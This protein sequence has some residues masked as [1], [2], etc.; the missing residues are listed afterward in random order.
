MRHAA[1]RD[2]V[3]AASDIVNA[4]RA[5]EDADLKREAAADLQAANLLDAALGEILKFLS[6]RPAGEK[7]A[8]SF[9]DETGRTRR[10]EGALVR[11]APG[12]L[13]LRNEEEA[14]SVETG[15]ILG[16]S[17][18]DLHRARPGAGSE[19][20]RRTA[21]LFCLLDGDAEAARRHVP[22]PGEVLP[23]KYWDLARALAEESR[24]GTE[25]ARR[26]AEARKIFR[27]AVREL[28]LP[29]TT[30][31]G[32]QKIGTLLEDFSGTA[33]VRRN[34]VSLEARKNAG[35]EYYFL[36]SDLAA[37]GTFRLG[38]S[39]KGMEALISGADVEGAAAKENFVEFEFSAFPGLE[40][41]CWALLGGCCR[42][43]FTFYQQATELTMPDPRNPRQKV[44]ADPGGACAPALK[45]S[46]PNL[47]PSHAAHGGKKEPT[48]FEWVPVPL[49]SYAS[50]GPKTVRL[51]AEV[52]GAAVARVLVSSVRKE[53][54]RDAELAELERTRA[55]E[56][57]LGLTVKPP[58]GKILREWWTGLQGGLGGLR[59][60]LRQK[61]SGSD[62][63]SSFAAPRDWADNYGTRIRGYLHPPKK[64][65]YVFWIA[66]DNESELWLSA[67]EDPANK[68]KIA[69][70][71]EWTGPTEW[72]KFKEQKSEPV[73]L[74]PGRRYYVE[75]LHVEGQGGDHVS[76]GWQL[77]DGTKE[78]PIPGER[79]SEFK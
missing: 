44:P 65:K 64:G 9:R 73:E 60:R 53:V 46:I 56:L 21:A 28:A 8:L 78:R 72:E 40:Y 51:L 54:P 30:W 32:A 48:R 3:S 25:A 61:P 5:L 1:A 42:D 34:R 31:A 52:Q 68:T 74:E 2:F 37:G 41:R 55:E 77:P 22:G 11:V 6:S 17:L 19:E 45:I 58:T 50:P 67:D 57:S 24:S 29:G 23:E 76:V 26:E 10:F 66:S 47:K 12:R 16:S 27:Q 63:L 35:R 33:F 79:L 14:V 49:P 36:P 13:L 43:T 4:S 69:G 18:A 39:P 71:R 70:V 59:G 20:D 7:I 38:R 15:E 75:V 62:L